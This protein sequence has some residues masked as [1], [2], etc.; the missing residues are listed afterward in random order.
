VPATAAPE[1]AINPDIF[2][3]KVFEN[4]RKLPGNA[5]PSLLP[6][7]VRLYLSDETVRLRKIETLA[8]EKRASTLAED[9]HSFG[10]NAASFGATQVQ[11]AALELERV[12]RH[13]DWPEV[14]KQ[15]GRLRDACATLRS[16]IVRLNLTA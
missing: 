3:V 14:A 5:G 13:D 6:E 9:A 1:E 4:T 11:E 2:N 12:A 16:E 15:L 10:G 8:A 7:L